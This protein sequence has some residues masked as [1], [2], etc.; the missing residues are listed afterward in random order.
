LVP[1]LAAAP[2]LHRRQ[3]IKGDKQMSD[4]RLTVKR[5]SWIV[6]PDDWAVVN[7][8]E[9]PGSEH[10]Y[11]GEWACGFGS[12]AEARAYIRQ[13]YNG[14]QSEFPPQPRLR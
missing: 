3:A 4:V 14:E 5:G 9:L 11:G 8:A 6:G 12:E 10:N 7:E 13:Y 2:V 1:A